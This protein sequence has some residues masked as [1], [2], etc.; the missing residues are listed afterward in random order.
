MALIAGL[1]L[2]CSRDDGKIAV[3]RRGPA[4]RACSFGVSP[5]RHSPGAAGP[6]MSSPP[7]GTGRPLYLRAARPAAAVPCLFASGGTRIL[8]SPSRTAVGGHR[9]RHDCWRCRRLGVRQ[10]LPLSGSA[11]LVGREID[12]LSKAWETRW[13]TTSLSRVCRGSTSRSPPQDHRRPLT[14]RELAP[15]ELEVADA[16]LPRR[17]SAGDRAQRSSSGWRRPG[18]ADRRR[19]RCPAAKL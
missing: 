4:D 14:R 1:A 12:A 16:D 15:Q 9:A 5:R 11:I 6:L 2:K 19:R 10:G 18:E 13:R 7:T 8:P 17:L 3:T